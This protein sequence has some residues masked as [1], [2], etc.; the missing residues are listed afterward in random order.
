MG[1]VNNNP[2]RPVALVLIS[3]T[4]IVLGVVY[5]QATSH[6]EASQQTALITKNSGM[7]TGSQSSTST[8]ALTLPVAPTPKPTTTT[9]QP[10]LSMPSISIPNQPT[11]P[12][13]NTPTTFTPTNW[14]LLTTA[15]QTI[16]QL[17]KTPLS[18]AY[19]IPE[20]K[21][22]NV[23]LAYTT[24]EPTSPVN[25]TPAITTSPSSVNTIVTTPL[26]SQDNEVISTLKTITGIYKFQQ[27]QEKFKDAQSK[28]AGKGKCMI[29]IGSSGC[30]MQW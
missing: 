10:N 28:Y 26:K 30:L 27:F 4:I 17:V 18:F 5:E 20:I 6:S 22:P 2:F 11:Q 8:P 25:T 24:I 16:E 13:I 21:L 14:T 3:L 29:V 7:T 12:I 9:N 23:A 19:S 15:L 1:E